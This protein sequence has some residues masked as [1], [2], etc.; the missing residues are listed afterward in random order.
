MAEV[1]SGKIAETR[2]AE[3][4]I[5][6]PD[7]SRVTVIVNIRPLK[8]QRGEITG[9]INSFFDVTERRAAQNA[10][11]ASE[12]AGRA[13]RPSRLRRT[14]VPRTVEACAPGG[15]DPAVVSPGGAA[16]PPDRAG[17]SG[18]EAPAPA[19]AAANP[20]PGRT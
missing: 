4:L 14:A 2:D 19:S 12:A 9:A 16:S 18:G 6:R 15:V 13:W 8:N 20:A 7:G 17:S 11:R 5:E 1:L 3:V 10:V